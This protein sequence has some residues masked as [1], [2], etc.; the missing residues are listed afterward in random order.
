VQVNKGAFDAALQK[1]IASKPTPL[2][3]IK[4][5]PARPAKKV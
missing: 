1:L 4:A 2:A 3:K 5:K